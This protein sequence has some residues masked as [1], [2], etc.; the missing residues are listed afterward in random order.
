MYCKIYIIIFKYIISTY[1]IRN[2]KK[3]QIKMKVLNMSSVIL[4]L[5]LTGYSLAGRLG[6]EILNGKRT[7]VDLDLANT[8]A[9]GAKFG[10]EYWT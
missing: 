7:S 2:N 10:L 9:G 3:E 4:I 8:Y 6:A 1:I 5:E